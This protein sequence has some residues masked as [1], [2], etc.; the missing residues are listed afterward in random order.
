MIVE[1]AIFLQMGEWLND[2]MIFKYGFWKALAKDMGG[3]YVGL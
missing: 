1:I 2:I 3:W